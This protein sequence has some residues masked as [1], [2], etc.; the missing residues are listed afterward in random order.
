M[1]FEEFAC[2]PA[3]ETHSDNFFEFFL[4]LVHLV[5]RELRRNAIPNL[6]EQRR[7][8]ETGGYSVR[9]RQGLPMLAR[10][11]RPQSA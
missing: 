11:H 2:E 9:S 5:T 1:V 7:V 4:D 10:V 3:F 6:L 8:R